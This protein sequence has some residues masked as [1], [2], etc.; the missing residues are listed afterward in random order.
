MDIVIYARFSY[1]GQREESIEGQLH[2]CYKYAEENNHN[3]IAEYI[4]RGKTATNDNRPQFQQMLADSKS[5]QFQAVLVYQLDRFAR[6]RYDSAFNK[7][8]LRDNGVI[9]ISATE[10]ISDS[11]EGKMLEGILEALAEYQSADMAQKIIRGHHVNAEKCIYNGGPVPLGYRIDS[12]RKYQLDDMNAAI[13]K[14]VF[15]DY[16]NGKTIVDIVEELNASGVKTCRGTNFTV[17]SF[18]TMLQN[19]RYTGCYIYSDI[20]IPDGIPR[21]IEDDLFNSVQEKIHRNKKAPSCKDRY[22]LTTKLFCG[23]C[24]SMMVG[25]SG[26]SH[27]GKV[28]SYYTCFD[29]KSNGCTIPNYPKEFLEDIIL[30]EC[31]KRLT[32][33]SIDVIANEV[34]L[35]YEQSF[36]TPL[37]RSLNA[38]ISNCNTAIL[39]LTKALELGEETDLILSRIKAKRT[40]L[41][42]FELQLKKET[43]G[44]EILGEDEI[45]FFLTELRNKNADSMKYKQGLIT[46]LINRIIVYQDRIIIVFNAGNT[47][48]EI[49]S[50]K[51]DE[52]KNTLGSYKKSSGVPIKT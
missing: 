11:P 4:D 14:K 40:E 41:R 12:D 38:E 43:V 37:I 35:L 1:S 19:K 15:N 46:A 42:N 17:N 13:V 2:A 24:N 45:K 25:T 26:T 31:R 6:N 36:D 3:V 34:S 52:L 10:N 16:N 8:K 47:H 7:K 21:I 51:I 30:E 20:T 28:Y 29:K 32:D 44:K 22:L 18:R 9:V 27:T 39:N 48:A 49:P 33:E 50:S 23:D 5:K